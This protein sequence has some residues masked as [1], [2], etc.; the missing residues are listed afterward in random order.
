MNINRNIDINIDMNI[1][2]DRSL[3]T[4]RYFCDCANHGSPLSG[5]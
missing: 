1:N 4:P 3:Q 2:I 5:K